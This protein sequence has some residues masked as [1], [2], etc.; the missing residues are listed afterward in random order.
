MTKELE[1]KE[2][3]KFLNDVHNII[4]YWENE[5][6]ENDTLKKRIE[7][8]AFSMLVLLDGGNDGNPGYKLI[9][10]NDEVEVDL[11][12]CLHEYFHDYIDKKR[13]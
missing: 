5:D 11:A 2:R 1:S 12:G 3:D 7:G 8:V 6:I 13:R 10:L 9:P 4:N